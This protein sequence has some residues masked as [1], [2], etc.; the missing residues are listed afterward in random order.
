MAGKRKTTDV[1]K[2]TE[3]SKP[4]VIGDPDPVTSV[5]TDPGPK[6]GAPVQDVDKKVREADRD[7]SRRQVAEDRH[8]SDEA[9]VAAGLPLECDEGRVAVI[10]AV[11]ADGASGKVGWVTARRID[12][13]L[14]EY[15][16]K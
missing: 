4:A 6:T 8:H 7:R 16:K 15:K 5:N 13:A 12:A 9:V 1:K 10:A 3:P 11:P 14:S 2:L